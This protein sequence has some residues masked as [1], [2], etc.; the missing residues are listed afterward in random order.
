MLGPKALIIGGGLLTSICVAGFSLIDNFDGMQFIV[1]GIGIRLLQGIGC[2]ATETGA[3][4]ML[5]GRFPE[6][7]GTI[8]GLMDV[9]NGFVPACNNAV[10]RVS[11]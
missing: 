2:A 1:F 5:A 8:T 9:R 6:S 11:R 3:T 10:T 4:A 7:I